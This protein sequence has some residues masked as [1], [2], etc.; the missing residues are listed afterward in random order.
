MTIIRAAAEFLKWRDRPTQTIGFIPTLGALHEGHFSLVSSSKQTCNLTVV[1][2]FLNPTQFALDEDLDSYPNTLDAD[3]SVLSNLDVDVLFLPSKEEM[4]DNVE[5]V[6]IPHMKLFDKLEGVSRPH[7]F[8]GVTQIIAKFFN[9][10]KPTHAF[11]GEKDAQQLIIINQMIEA[12]KYNIKLVPCP[13]V[14]DK[15]GLALS[16][17][18]QYLSR[19]DQ[20]AAAFLNRCLLKIKKSLEMGEISSLVLK[21]NF[22]KEISMSG[23]FKLDYISIASKKT[24]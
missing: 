20:V 11:F 2:I 9:V 5:G 22:Q 14:R 8:N 16:S 19:R 13:T 10:I 15:N 21:Q 12:M 23:K 3:I 4:Y 6:D 17:R 18:N 1:S 7:F 24:G